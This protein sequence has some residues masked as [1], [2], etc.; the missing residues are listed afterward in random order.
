MSACGRYRH[1]GGMLPPEHNLAARFTERRA[2]H[3]LRLLPSSPDSA[4]PTGSLSSP[5]SPSTSRLSSCSQKTRLS[6]LTKH[7]KHQRRA[8]CRPASRNRHGHRSAQYARLACREG[9]LQIPALAAPLLYLFHRFDGTRDKQE[10]SDLAVGRIRNPPRSLPSESSPSRPTTDDR[11]PPEHASD[12]LDQSALGLRMARCQGPSP[13]R[14]MLS[15]LSPRVPT[16][17]AVPENNSPI[18]CHHADASVA[19]VHSGPAS[20]T[21][22][23]PAW[24]VLEPERRDVDLPLAFHPLPLASLSPRI[25]SRALLLLILR[26][27]SSFHVGLVRA[28]CR[29]ARR[30]GRCVSDASEPER[31]SSFAEQDRLLDLDEGPR[32]WVQLSTLCRLGHQDR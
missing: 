15:S 30:C 27:A 11:P 16:E 4:P 28:H 29:R 24:Y 8:T 32:L 19:S 31:S 13:T 6:G 21:E 20:R 17:S 9:P 3:L 1:E 12:A 7:N 10:S 14:R 25:R 23:A 18:H 22:R 26:H 5:S 2:H